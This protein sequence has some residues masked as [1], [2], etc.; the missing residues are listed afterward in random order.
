MGRG[1]RVDVFNDEAFVVF[2]NF[3]RRNLAANDFAEEAILRHAN[4]LR[5]GWNFEKPA[6]AQSSRTR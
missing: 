4:N 5:S 2:V 3:L 1:L 6:A